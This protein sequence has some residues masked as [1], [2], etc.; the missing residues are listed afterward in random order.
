MMP[1]NPPMIGKLS[2][3]ALVVVSSVAYQLAQRSVPATANAYVVF[4]LV[5]LLGMVACLSITFL[6]ARPICFA[7]IQLLRTWPAWTL[8]ASV[9]GIEVGYLWVY[10]TGWPLGAAVGVTYTL[11]VVLLALIGAAFFSEELSLRR[12]AGVLFALT[13]L[14]LL[15]EPR[16]RA[17]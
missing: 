1:I 6:A 4:S 3:I 13:G 16:S 9:V 12:I 17:P 7:D 14:W 15:I 2:P 10:R 8:G 11:T 5:Y